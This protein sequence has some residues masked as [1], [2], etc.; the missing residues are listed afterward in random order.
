MCRF[1]S[2]REMEQMAHFI[3][4]PSE[5]DDDLKIVRYDQ[6]ERI[7]HLG[8]G[9]KVNDFESIKSP[10]NGLSEQHYKDASFIFKRQFSVLREQYAWAVSAVLGGGLVQKLYVFLEIMING[11]SVGPPKVEVFSDYLVDHILLKSEGS[12][13]AAKRKTEQ[14]LLSEFMWD[15]TAVLNAMRN[16]ISALKDELILV[17]AVAK[18]LNTVLD[19]MLNKMTS[20]PS[21]GPVGL[22]TSASQ[23]QTQ[24]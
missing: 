21:N 2:P 22:S 24:N 12:V 10:V 23:N 15:N 7:A 11:Y 5:T 9:M 13:K 8:T 3:S 20:K 18:K 17:E 16:N 19:K 14:E 6:K 4:G 1:T